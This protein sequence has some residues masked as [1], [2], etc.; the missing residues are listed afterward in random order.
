MPVMAVAGSKHAR[1]PESEEVPWVCVSFAFV[2][3][4][5]CVLVLTVLVP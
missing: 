3:L 5:F 4:C 2:S 1:S